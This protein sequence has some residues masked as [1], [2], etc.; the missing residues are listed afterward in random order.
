MHVSRN[1]KAVVCIYCWLCIDTCILQVWEVLELNIYII[2]CHTCLFYIL[3]GWSP[4]VMVHNKLLTVQIGHIFV[5]MLEV[6]VLNL[7]WWIIYILELHASKECLLRWFFLDLSQSTFC[8]NP[9]VKVYTPF[10]ES[11]S[12]VDKVEASILALYLFPHPT[13]MPIVSIMNTQN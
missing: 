4:L 5:P 9:C 3:Y 8:E 7:V 11:V 10:N 1:S 12:N 6:L 2:F 13:W